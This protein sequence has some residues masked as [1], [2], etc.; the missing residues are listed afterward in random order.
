MSKDNVSIR[1]SDE[2]K[3]YLEL[4][5]TLITERTG[6]EVNRSQIILMLMEHGREGLEKQYRI[7]NEIK[8]FFD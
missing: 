3:E 6:I 7:K 4:L 8:K 2:V 1:L 5:V